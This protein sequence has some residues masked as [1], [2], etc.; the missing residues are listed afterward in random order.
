[1]TLRGL[2]I[3][4]AYGIQNIPFERAKMGRDLL[5]WLDSKLTFTSHINIVVGKI[6]RMVGLLIVHFRSATFRI[7]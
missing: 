2:P 4:T 1:M 5:I 7:V 6:N 3:E